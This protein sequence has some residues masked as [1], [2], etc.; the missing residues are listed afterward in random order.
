VCIT[1][2]ELVVKTSPCPGQPAAYKCSV[3][4]EDLVWRWLTDPPTQFVV[5]SNIQPTSLITT[6][7]VGGIEVVFNTTEYQLNPSFISVEAVVSDPDSLNG[8][9]ISCGGQSLVIR[10]P[11]TSEWMLCCVASYYDQII[12]ISFC[13]IAGFLPTAL[14]IEQVLRNGSYIFINLHFESDS[15][16]SNILYRSSS[17]DLAAWTGPIRLRAPENITFLH[18]Q[19]NLTFSLGNNGGKIIISI[20]M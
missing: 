20:I 19:N 6:L 1:A 17:S 10:V 15:A 9:T 8:V 7:V 3:Q 16:T 11:Q 13:D 18:C 4:N 12:I 5:V 14:Q 2:G